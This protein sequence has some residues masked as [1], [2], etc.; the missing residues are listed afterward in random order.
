MSN[1]KTE[2]LELNKDLKLKSSDSLLNNHDD[3]INKALATAEKVSQ[4]SEINQSFTIKS[5]NIENNASA[6]PTL[7]SLDIQLGEKLESSLKKDV[8]PSEFKI[9]SANNDGLILQAL[10]I[11]E[12]VTKKCVNDCKD[13]NIFSNKV[14]KKEYKL[15]C[16]RNCVRL[17]KTF[18]LNQYARQIFYDALKAHN[19]FR[20]KHGHEPLRFNSRISLIAQEYADLMARQ[21]HIRHSDNKYLNKDLGENLYSFDIRDTS[22]SG[23]SITRE[24]YN[25]IYRYDFRGPQYGTGHFTQLIWKETREIGFGLAVSSNGRVYFVANYFPTGNVIGEFSK[26]VNKLL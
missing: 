1:Y 23:E 11:A 12:N 8:N 26:N 18:D 7:H 5:I 22:I 3:L 21:N 16:N 24:W 9:E 17:N 6:G 19:F 25:E 2:S 15:I 10:K 14:S 13:D 4:Q 20:Q